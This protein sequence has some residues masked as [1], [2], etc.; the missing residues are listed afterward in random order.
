MKEKKTKKEG[1]K[2]KLFNQM[3]RIKYS[4]TV[5]KKGKWS[6]GNRKKN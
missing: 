2:E 1:K 5:K 6:R 3:K 4:Y